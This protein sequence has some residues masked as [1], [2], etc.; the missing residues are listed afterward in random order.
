MNKKMGSR[1]KGVGLLE[2]MLAL[3]ISAVIILLSVRYYQTTSN[4]QKVSAA[5]N[6]IRGV[7]QATQTYASRQNFV[8]TDL[9]ISSLQSA[10]LL[11]STYNQ[12]P[13]GG[14]NSL[15][16]AVSGNNACIGG[17]SST[18]SQCFV[19]TL[20]NIPG[21][22]TGTCDQIRGRITQT[23]NQTGSAGNANEFA[24][25]APNGGTSKLVVEYVLY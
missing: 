24:G 10:G 7:Y 5:V 21:K 3:A 16:V 14:A 12:G 23:L 18:V 25:C 20:S 2:I 11:N 6:Q 9:S 13:W 1:S 8:A 19:V 15:T 4:N 17:A 22:T